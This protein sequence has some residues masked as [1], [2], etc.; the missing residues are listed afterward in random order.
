MKKFIERIK[1]YFL[2]QGEPEKEKPQEEKPQEQKPE[3]KP[4]A[5]LQKGEG[6]KTTH[7]IKGQ[8][9]GGEFKKRRKKY[10]PTQKNKGAK[11]SHG[12]MKDKPV[13]GKK[14]GPEPVRKD[15][16][17]KSHPGKKASPYRK[18]ENVK[19]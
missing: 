5:H 14:T 15:S 6:T 10:F 18:R 17:G 12:T 8:E 9:K 4:I 16:K 3:E 19:K 1:K 7:G 2:G 11:T 13:E